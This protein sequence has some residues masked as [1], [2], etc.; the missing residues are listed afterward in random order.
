[1][2]T[3][4]LPGICCGLET[5]ASEYGVVP[6]AEGSIRPMTSIGST[7]SA[8]ANSREARPDRCMVVDGMDAPVR[9]RLMYVGDAL[10]R[11]RCVICSGAAS[12]ESMPLAPAPLARDLSGLC[13]A[14]GW[15]AWPPQGAISIDSDRVG[16]ECMMIRKTLEQTGSRLLQPLTSTVADAI[17]VLTLTS[18]RHAP[19]LLKKEGSTQVRRFLIYALKDFLGFCFCFAALPAH[20]YNYTDPSAYFPYI[21][22]I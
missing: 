11:E 9:I 7:N 21:S 1:M 15:G 12:I 13:N 3:H 2:H 6:K 10:M 19:T 8:I 22:T 18:P 16:S 17:V 5:L 14:W 20:I 4:A